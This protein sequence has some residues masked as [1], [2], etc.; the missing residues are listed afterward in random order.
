[1]VY[2][3]LMDSLAKILGDNIARERLIRGLS[4]AELGEQLKV[5]G[6]TVYRWE[7]QKTWPPPENIEALAEL[8]KVPAWSF[9]MPH[10][11]EKVPQKASSDP[12]LREALSVLCR[13]LGFSLAPAKGRGKR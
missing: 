11:P 1:M 7:H 3:Y 9:Y 4:Q 12:K 8:F 6:Q 2:P 10:K 13:A 5:Q